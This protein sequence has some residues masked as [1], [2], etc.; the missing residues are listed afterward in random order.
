MF[1]QVGTVDP[2]GDFCTLIS[3]RDEDRFDEGMLSPCCPVE[4]ADHA[5][6]HL[7]SAKQQLAVCRDLRYQKIIKHFV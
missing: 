6:S 4:L 3:Q 1:F 5:V 2:A 7:T